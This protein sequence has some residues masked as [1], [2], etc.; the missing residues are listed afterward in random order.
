VT[1]ARDR[2]SDDDVDTPEEPGRPT[3]GAEEDRGDRPEPSIE[4][5]HVDAGGDIGDG[6]D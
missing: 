6:A 3:S 4:D 2:G 5:V 1:A